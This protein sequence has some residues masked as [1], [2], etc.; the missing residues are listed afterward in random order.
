VE[1]TQVFP[2]LAPFG[3]CRLCRTGSLRA[4]HVSPVNH[5]K[6]RATRQLNV[7]LVGCSHCGVAYGH[8]LPTEAELA[9]Y[10]SQA[11][12]W[13]D[14]IAIERA[15]REGAARLH[16]KQ[17]K[18]LVDLELLRTLV[19]L[20]EPTPGAQRRALDFGCGIGGW[21]SALKSAGW[22]TYGVEPGPRAAAIAAR[23]HVLIPEVP[24]DASFDLAILHHTLEH[25]ADPIR[26]VSDLSASLRPD[27]VIWISVP[28]FDTLGEHQD[29]DYVTSDKHVFSYTA[30]ALG[31]LL[32]LTGFE[33]VAHSN[34]PTWPGHVS[35]AKRLVAIGRRAGRPAPLAEAPLDTALSALAAYGATRRFPTRPVPPGPLRRTMRGL[36]SWAREARRS[37][38][39]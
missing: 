25:L 17:Q 9:A 24:R 23:E 5:N 39:A 38:R 14:R 16:A 22:S 11:G 10:Y 4:L 12:G 34:D 35:G 15:E 29:I 1:P 36:R 20:P 3:A 37:A 28:N 13:D 18:H 30:A 21:L 7:A 19:P 33:L 32:S 26:V 6:A 8:P 31:S 27:G 2:L